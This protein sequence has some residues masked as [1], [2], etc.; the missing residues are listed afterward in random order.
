M[1]DSSKKDLA[2][3]QLKEAFG[4]RRFK[5]SRVERAARIL[6]VSLNE[7]GSNPV[8]GCSGVP[9]EEVGS[10]AKEDLAEDVI[11]ALGMEIGP[12]KVLNGRT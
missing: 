9:W 5:I 10:E 8:R 7:N 1:K 11:E 6:G 4:G 3:A 2:K 12:S